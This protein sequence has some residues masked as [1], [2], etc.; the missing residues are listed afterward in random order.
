MRVGVL[1]SGMV[2][3]ALAR[4]FAGRGHEVRIG[5]R[6]PAKLADFAEET[7]V[8]TGTFD[9]VA[10]HGELLVLAT[11]G[12]AAVD[13][14]ALTGH[15]DLDGKVL[16]DTTNPLAFSGDGPPKLFVGWSDSLGEQIQ[17]AAPGARVV[18][19]FNIITAG[20]M[21]EP[22]LVGGPPTMFLAGDD[23]AAKETVIGVLHDFGWPDVVDVGGIVGARLLEPLCL[24]WVVVGARRGAW[25]HGFRLLLGTP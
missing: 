15:G 4:G 7:G 8:G 9:E 20:E 14:L 2:G 16:I 12:D 18:K 1:G 6:E 23:D 11:R 21:V 5:S 3:Q 17:R 10:A 19:C 24:L 22:D 25:D 13:A